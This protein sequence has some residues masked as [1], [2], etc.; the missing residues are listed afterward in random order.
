QRGE[1]DD[2]K[3]EQR[4]QPRAVCD[5]P[6]REQQPDLALGDRSRA[7][8]EMRETEPAGAVGRS[9]DPGRERD[10]ADNGGAGSHAPTIHALTVFHGGLAPERPVSLLTSTTREVV[11]VGR[12]PSFLEEVPCSQSGRFALPCSPFSVSCSCPLRR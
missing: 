4:R 12:C 10:G 2:R 7:R 8:C 1:A 11:T 9:R 3:A 5:N 6:A